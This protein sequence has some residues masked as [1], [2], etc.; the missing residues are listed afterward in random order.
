[1]IFL[2]CRYRASWIC[3]RSS[4]SAELAQVF[5][6]VVHL[7]IGLDR[8]GKVHREV[9][10]LILFEDFFGLGLSWMMRHSLRNS[11]MRSRLL[12]TFSFGSNISWTFSTVTFS[13]VTDMAFLNWRRMSIFVGI[14]EMEDMELL[15]MAQK[16][17]ESESEAK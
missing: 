14:P 2:R 8:K 7:L 11:S 12:G 3:S 15:K 1:M 6:I 10:V 17:V 16:Q 13:G 4:R 9:L 5:E